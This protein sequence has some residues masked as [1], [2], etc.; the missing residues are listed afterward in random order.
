MDRWISAS[1]TAVWAGFHVHTASPSA[2]WYQDEDLQDH[3]L[4]SPQNHQGSPCS[5]VMSGKTSVKINRNCIF[6]RVF[7]MTHSAMEI[8]SNTVNIEVAWCKKRLA[9]LWGCVKTSFLI[10]GLAGSCYS[11]INLSSPP[12]ILIPKKE[13]KTNNCLRSSDFFINII[14]RWVLRCPTPRAW[15]GYLEGSLS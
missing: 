14:N 13:T 9:R 4:L 7:P 5:V 12:N 10:P 6:S 3:V 2:I 15:K 11:V 8:R 1:F